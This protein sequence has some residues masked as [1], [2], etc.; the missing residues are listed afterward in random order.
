[1]AAAAR[2]IAKFAGIFGVGA[3]SGYFYAL[4]DAEELLI[5]P[6]TFANL[7]FKP[8]P[9]KNSHNSID[10]GPVVQWDYNWDKRDFMVIFFLSSKIYECLTLCF[11]KV[12]YKNDFLP[13]IVSHLNE[14]LR[15]IIHLST[16]ILQSTGP[17]VLFKK[18]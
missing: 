14:T 2:A 12:L 7:E 3:G 13:I 4:Y 1:M 6:P 15:N 8:A 17:F 5:K 9:L 10:W 11:D 16:A 18:K